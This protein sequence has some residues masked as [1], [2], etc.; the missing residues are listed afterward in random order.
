MKKALT[1][2]YKYDNILSQRGNKEKKGGEKSGQDRKS[3]EGT[4]GGGQD[5]RHDHKR[6]GYDHDHQAEAR[7]GK[8]K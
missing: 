1:Y 2:L 8:A 7:Q 3:P 5:Q 4:S 6:Q